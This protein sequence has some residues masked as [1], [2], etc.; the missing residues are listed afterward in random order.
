VVV[1]WLAA[2]LAGSQVRHGGDIITT[3]NRSIK[4]FDIMHDD[5]IDL[6]TLLILT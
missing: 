6:T 2:G 3:K 4:R 1:V 5:M